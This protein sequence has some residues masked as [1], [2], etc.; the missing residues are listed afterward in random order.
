MK[1]LADPASRWHRSLWAVALVTN[2]DELVEAARHTWSGVLS[3]SHALADFK[4]SALRACS[5]DPGIGPDPGSTKVADAIKRVTSNPDA[6][7][8]NAAAEVEAWRHKI[9]RNYL[10]NW[11][12][13]LEGG[14][15]EESNVEMCARSVVSH[16]RSLGYSRAHIQGWLTERG[17][18]RSIAALAR[19]AAGHLDGRTREYQFTVA[20]DELAK[21]SKREKTLEVIELNGES[22]PF[23]AAENVDGFDLSNL[24]QNRAVQIS[25]HAPDPFSALTILQLRIDRI[26]TRLA[27]A[28]GRIRK[29]VYPVV[30]ETGSAKPKLWKL[31]DP[32]KL[33]QIPDL[34]HWNLITDLESKALADT[35]TETLHLLTPQLQV[36][37]GVSLATLWASCEALLGRT[38]Q[39]GHLVA[40]RM[41]AILACAYPRQLAFDLLQRAKKLKQSGVKLEARTEGRSPAVVLREFWEDIAAND[42]GFTEPADQA[43][44]FRFRATI[45]NPKAQ[46][47][48]VRKYLEELLLRLYY[49][50]NFVM[51][52]AK[53]NTVSLND[54]A[55]VAPVIVAAALSEMVSGI[56]REVA[57]GALADRAAIELDLLGTD[58]AKPLISLLS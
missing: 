25:C 16:L 52:S 33:I 23:Q 18:S 56:A 9:G 29:P 12:A 26:M 10:R 2:L 21:V 32:G 43:A 22:N 7:S 49:H 44:Y 1:E 11:A 51:H 34:T 28:E 41:A 50:R 39:G 27:L 58:A 54:V 38:G 42:P 14:G 4:S 31:E 24:T 37:H 19:E 45:A 47:K 17:D 55:G 6:D 40:P 5:R 30:L 3:R 36:A 57:P 13:F 8:K 20:S 53:T 35:L 15:L 46:L 48:R